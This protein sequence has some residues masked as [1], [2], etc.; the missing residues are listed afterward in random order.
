M[1]KNFL[2]L[3][4]LDKLNPLYSEIVK[5]YFALSY[6][7]LDKYKSRFSLFDDHSVTHSLRVLENANNLISANI[8]KLNAEE[9][10]IFILSA[11]SHDLGMKTT[12]NFFDKYYEEILDK[13]FLNN[14]KQMSRF[15]LIRKFHNEF[16]AKIL[17]EEEPFKTFMPVNLAKATGLLCKGH[18]NYDLN[19][20][21]MF[22]TDY[23]LVVEELNIDAVVNIAYLAPILRLSD[24][25]DLTE[26][27]G[28][29]IEYDKISEFWVG[30]FSSRTFI[31][32]IEFTDDVIKIVF[33][34]KP[35]D[36]EGFVGLREEIIK[37]FEYCK[38]CIRNN[39]DFS[40]VDKL[41]LYYEDF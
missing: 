31:P 38:N 3:N 36:T 16:S 40:I 2:L 25:L 29:S 4:K 41:E 9:I 27:R 19:D 1:D 34:S 13:D 35:K 37:E 23:H 17:L 22:P 33:T 5:E 20:T 18:R 12:D 7:E 26:E 10:L 28:R 24:E 8:E 15:E 6:T 11:Y 39:T 32:N 14:N 30:Y 21:N